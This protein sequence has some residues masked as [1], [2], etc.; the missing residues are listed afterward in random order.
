MFPVPARAVI[1]RN[2]PGVIV[3]ALIAETIEHVSR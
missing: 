3:P 1:I 2:G